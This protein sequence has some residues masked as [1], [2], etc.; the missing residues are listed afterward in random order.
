[1]LESSNCCNATR[2]VDDDDD[3]DDDDEED[4]DPMIGPTGEKAC[5]VRHATKKVDRTVNAAI[6]ENCTIVRR[7]ISIVGRARRDTKN[8]SYH[9]II[10]Y[11][12]RQNEETVVGR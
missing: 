12:S 4:S 3:D 10:I 9:I 1:M 6:D 7:N 11:R 2:S 8:L 5:D